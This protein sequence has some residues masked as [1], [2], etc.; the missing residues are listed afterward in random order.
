MNAVQWKM[1]SSK[2]NKSP[3]KPELPVI[4][5]ANQ[6]KRYLEGLAKWQRRVK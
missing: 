3:A 1:R 4:R 5:M 2:W 6:N